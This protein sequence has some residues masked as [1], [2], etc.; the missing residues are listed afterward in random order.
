M[1]YSIDLVA[2]TSALAA[3]LFG[4]PEAGSLLKALSHAGRLGISAANKAELLIV[5]RRRLG[6]AGVTKALDLLAMYG[7]AVIAVDD[8]GAELAAEAFERF[9]KGRHPAGL[10]FGDCFAY[11]LARQL[12]APLLF[13]GDDFSKTDLTAA[14]Y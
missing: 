5:V 3:I 11:A 4:E 7:V 14:P 1:D 13:K 6:A 12:N 10:N 8:A 2:D 9:G